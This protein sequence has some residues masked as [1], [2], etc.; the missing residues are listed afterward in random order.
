MEITTSFDKLGFEL[1]IEE[2]LILPKIL[3]HNLLAV[4]SVFEYLIR[5]HS[6]LIHFYLNHLQKEKQSSKGLI[7]SKRSFQQKIHSSLKL[8][9][10]RLIAVL[11]GSILPNARKMDHANIYIAFLY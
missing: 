3:N 5:I 2:Q 1:S 8:L 7:L 11:N 6:L 9:L 4:Y 10:N